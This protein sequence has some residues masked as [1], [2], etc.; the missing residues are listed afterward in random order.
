MDVDNNLVVNKR[1]YR[2]NMT[3]YWLEVLMKLKFAE[4]TDFYNTLDSDHYMI[5]FINIKPIKLIDGC[6]VFGWRNIWLGIHCIDL[7]F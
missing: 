7:I 4:S 6:H 2:L 3:F 5:I 1:V